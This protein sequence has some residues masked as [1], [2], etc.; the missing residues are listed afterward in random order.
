MKRIAVVSL[1]LVCC[2]ACALG[3]AS[4]A[5]V[6][7]D[8]ARLPMR[9]MPL[10]SS[11]VVS[12]IPDGA[13]VSVEEERDGWCFVT[14]DRRSGYVPSRYL[15]REPEEIGDAFVC[16]ASASPDAPLPLT[17]NRARDIAD[18]ALARVYPDF[19]PSEY[20]VVQVTYREDTQDY[21]TYY[22]FEYFCADGSR[23]Y[24]CV[25]DAYTGGILKLI[26]PQQ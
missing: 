18:A 24:R 12:Y 14:Y 9:W 11:S 3:E 7:A 8:G 20:G 16:A 21:G 17:Q 1:V 10:A 25:V 5:F 23:S 15:M 13:A 2:L 4:Q 26:P 19:L 22:G 6:R